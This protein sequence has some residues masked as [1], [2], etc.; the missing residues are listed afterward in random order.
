MV[1]HVIIIGGGH[2]GLAAAA[3]LA[4]A[5]RSVVLVESRDV[6]GGRAAREEFHPGFFSPGLL[7][8][9][10]GLR[11]TLIDEL[12]LVDHG[13]DLLD[14]E[15]DVLAPAGD[16]SAV[17]RQGNDSVSGENLSPADLQ[18]FEAWRSAV[19]R[20]TPFLRRLVDS[21]APQT[22]P[23]GLA[24]LWEL[25]RTGLAMRKL[26]Q[27]TMT[28]LLRVG[29][30]CIHDWLDESMEHDRLKALL[31]APALGGT[32]LGSWS[33]GSAALLLLREATAERSARGGPAAI[34]AALVT[35]ARAAGATL[36][37]GTRVQRVLLSEDRVVGVELS[38][39]EVLNG[40]AVLSAASPRHTLLELLGRGEAPAHLTQRMARWRV[41]GTTA[42]LR[43][44][45]NGP[46]L[47]AGHDQPVPRAHVIGSLDDIERSMDAVKYDQVSERPMLDVSVPT[48]LD[49]TLAPNGQQVLTVLASYVPH[50]H[51]AGW[52][53]EQKQLL[54]Q[55][56]LGTLA[57]VL[58]DI[59][60]RIAGHELLTPVD[61]EA[62][63]GLTGG[64]LHHG[65]LALDQ[66]LHMRPDPELSRN[67]TPIAGLWLAGAGCHP[68]PGL[69]GASGRL[70]ARAMIGKR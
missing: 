57:T 68:G 36:R 23:S 40:D 17:L 52:G 69:C 64:Q 14:R 38:T 70:A 3:T 44:A 60:S 4:G 25:A 63:Y 47:F 26:G 35:A 56:I 16:G 8:D 46:V 45:V 33:V 19:L 43:L 7:H 42:A 22:E 31:A 27:R 13:L 2:D 65:E 48:V 11:P 30:M 58:P 12:R 18:G 50:A 62:R 9:S 10:A 37:S 49:P 24:D 32:W 61:I 55:K 53:D 51:R 20:L 59:E 34:T 29:P 6:F 67:A 28:E 1:R 21:P 39:G 41:R 15:P 54:L 66:L 5:G